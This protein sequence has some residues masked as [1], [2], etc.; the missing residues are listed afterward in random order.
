MSVRMIVSNNG[1]G[2]GALVVRTAS[3]IGVDQPADLRRLRSGRVLA[4]KVGS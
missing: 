2:F 3:V 4:P 1:C